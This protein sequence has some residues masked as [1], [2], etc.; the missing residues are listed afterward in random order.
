MVSLFGRAL[1]SLACIRVVP[2]L[3]RELGFSYT[4]FLTSKVL[5]GPLESGLLPSAIMCVK[6]LANYNNRG[7][8]VSIIFVFLIRLLSQW[9]HWHLMG[10]VF[11]RLSDPVKMR[12]VGRPKNTVFGLNKFVC[13]HAP[14]RSKLW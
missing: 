2:N 14:F 11:V 9:V 10:L 13:S 6:N 3:P 12:Y 1:V 7:I 5:L 8:L 4:R